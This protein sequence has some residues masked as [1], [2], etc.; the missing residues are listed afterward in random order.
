MTIADQIK[1][2]VLCDAHS[3]DIYE[4]L[5]CSRS[6]ISRVRTRCGKSKLK[7]GP[8]V[9]ARTKERRKI[10]VEM[11]LSGFTYFAIAKAIKISPTRVFDILM[12]NAKKGPGVAHRSKAAQKKSL[13]DTVG[14][15]IAFVEQGERDREAIGHLLFR[16]GQTMQID[17]MSKEE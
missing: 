1:K 7:S 3:S 8:R 5:K 4:K 6:L 13:E 2:L 12:Y 15:L 14:A 11:K 9:A 17:H 10:I 16:I